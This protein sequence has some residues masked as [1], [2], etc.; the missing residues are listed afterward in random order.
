M[1][2]THQSTILSYMPTTPGLSGLSLGLGPAWHSLPGLQA[3]ALGQ[4]AGALSLVWGAPIA[5]QHSLH[6]RPAEQRRLLTA[7]LG[8][9]ASYYLEADHVTEKDLDLHLQHCD[10]YTLDIS[11]HLGRATTPERKEQFLRACKSWVGVLS[12]TGIQRVLKVSER[13]LQWFADYYLLAIDEAF[14]RYSQIKAQRG[15]AHTVFE[16]SLDEVPEAQS[17]QE[18]FFLLL[19][20]QQV[21]LGFQVISPKF[22]GRWCR[23]NDFGGD[24]ALFEQE[25]FESICVIR[26]AVRFFGMH[27]HLKLS[28]PHAGDKYLLFPILQRALQQG[29]VGLHIQLHEQGLLDVFTALATTGP[30]G[31]ALVRETYLQA[32]DRFVELC[33]PVGDHLEIEKDELPPADVI[34]NWSGQRMAAALQHSWRSREYNPHL[35]QLMSVTAKLLTELGPRYTNATIQHAAAITAQ[36]RHTLVA[37]HLQPLGFVASQ[38]I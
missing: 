8:T 11:Q 4:A 16:I 7:Q 34:T 25:L 30:Q 27:R 6:T 10:Y 21:G 35:R 20:M 14:K 38:G 26:H 18:L 13:W 19:S 23:G 28:I 3:Q 2:T 31:L 9:G 24:S 29:G 12:I 5:V 37:Q 1:Q 32:L 22:S 33:A 15:R 36:L 17:P